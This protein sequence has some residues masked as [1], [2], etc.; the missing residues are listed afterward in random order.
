MKHMNIEISIAIVQSRCKDKWMNDEPHENI[1]L[2]LEKSGQKP[3]N[4]HK[5]EGNVSL[6]E[7]RIEQLQNLYNVLGL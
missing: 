4:I 5:M 2:W 7:R 3:W 1:R 6:G